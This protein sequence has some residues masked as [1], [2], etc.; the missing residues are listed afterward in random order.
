MTWEVGMTTS[1]ARAGSATGGSNGTLL[2]AL[3]LVLGVIGFEQLLHTGPGGP[4][5]YQ[6]LHWLS[7]SL[8]ALPLG[9]LAVW[10]GSR[11]AGRRRRA[12][13][14]DTFA[15][16]CLIAIVFAALLVPGSLVH[17]QIDTLTQSH[18]AISVHTHGGLVATRSWSDPDVLFAY[19]IHAFSDG[20]IGQLVGLPV[21]VAVLT[22]LARR[23]P[24][25]AR[26]TDSAIQVGRTSVA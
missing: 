16:A 3:P 15:R 5:V 2:M 17:E 13:A 24:L 9:L 4:P 20:I 6:A 19:V 14:S 7:D 8:M 10:F 18:R 21:L 23:R 12:G 26:T 25:R 1:A 22:W 11:L